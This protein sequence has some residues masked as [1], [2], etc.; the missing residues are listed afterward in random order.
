MF[1]TCSTISS[2]EILLNFSSF[3]EVME[4]KDRYLIFQVKRE[5]ASIIFQSQVISSYLFVILSEQSVDE[6]LG[7]N[8]FNIFN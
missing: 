2:R 7:K 1:T 6:L 8:Y 5:W 4:K 3:A